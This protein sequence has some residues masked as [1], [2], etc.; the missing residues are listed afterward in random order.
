MTSPGRRVRRRSA[1][2][3]AADAGAPFPLRRRERAQLPFKRDV[4]L[5]TTAVLIVALT[6]LGAAIRVGVN[7]GLSVDEILTVNQAHSSFGGLISLLI[8]RGTHPP[9]HPVLEWCALHLVGDGTFAMRLPA[10][11]AGTALIPVV[12]ML[13]RELFDRL[14]AIVA[15]LLACLAPILVWYSQDASSYALVALFG[16]VAVLGAVRAERTGAP[17]DWA[18]HAVGAALCIWSDWSG[19]FI[20]L[21]SEIVIAAG[22]ARRRRVPAD[23]RAFLVRWGLETLALAAQLAVLGALFVSQLHANGGLSGVTN[24]AASG[25]S[26]YS[27]VS[28]ASWALFGFH[29]QSVTSVLSAVWP[30]AM[31]GSLLLVGRG[32]SRN[33]WLLLTCVLVPTIGVFILGLATPASYDV[34]YAIAAV[35]PALVIVARV[36]VSWPRGRTGRILVTLGVVVVLAAALVDQQVDA[37]NPRRYDYR[38]ALAQVQREAQGAPRRAVVF[39]APAQLRVVLAHYG[40]TL[41]SAP[42]SR[43]LPTRAQASSVFVATSGARQPATLQ[44]VNRELG[45]LRSTRHLV[46]FRRYS[47][48]NVWWFR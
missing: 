46:R 45:A 35:P 1:A 6:A 36:A 41:H 17:R 32:G 5:A 13:A 26:F 11:I 20:V 19:I 29:P 25:V 4:S 10:L 14:T 12:A 24:V 34:R 47:G 31:L 16:T 37:N 40:P 8:H 42:L 39:Y 44:L 23:S 38:E 43:H 27:S 2:D 9:L 21:A 3:R 30:L 22:W 28:I 7:R 33:G 18:L 15:A 48:I